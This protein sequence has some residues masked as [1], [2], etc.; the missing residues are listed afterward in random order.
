MPV[1]YYPILF[2]PVLFVLLSTISSHFPE[3][4]T[5][6]FSHQKP[7]TPILLNEI[8]LLIP[9]SIFHRE[10]YPIRSQSPNFPFAFYPLPFSKPY[11]YL[12]F[13][14]IP[15]H[16]FPLVTPTPPPNHTLHQTSPSLRTTNLTASESH[17]PRFATDETAPAP[18]FD[19]PVVPYFA[20][21][22]AAGHGHGEFG[23]VGEVEGGL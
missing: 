19:S 8:E 1:L 20:V 16:Y 10:L 5:L 9:S 11:Y 12:L 18:T 7:P 21:V 6:P 4:N 14:S 2:C 13:A 22:G 3:K 15:I 23:V 17:F